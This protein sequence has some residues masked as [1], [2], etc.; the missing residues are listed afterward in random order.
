MPLPAFE[1]QL[2]KTYFSLPMQVNYVVESLPIPHYT[3][4]D[5]P[6]LHILGKPF[7]YFNYYLSKHC[8]LKLEPNF[9]L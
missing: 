9:N 3:H 8:Q 4:A 2:Y 7:L 5:T 1:P 6:S